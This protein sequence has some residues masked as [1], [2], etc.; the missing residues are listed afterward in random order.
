MQ[1]NE[2]AE[3]SKQWVPNKCE[4]EFKPQNWKKKKKPYVYWGYNSMVECMPS[5]CKD[6]GNSQHQTENSESMFIE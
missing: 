3:W 1:K 4:A 5:M 6:L 2:Q